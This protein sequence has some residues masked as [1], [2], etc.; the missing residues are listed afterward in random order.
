MPLTFAEKI[1]IIIG[2]RNMSFVDL[3]EKMG[4]TRQNISNK[5]AKG[6]FS[7]SDMA[8]IADL[9]NCDYVGPGLKMRDT[10]EEI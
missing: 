1:K 8:K 6:N 3:A 10:G 9:L 4:T 5:M 7:E 2:R